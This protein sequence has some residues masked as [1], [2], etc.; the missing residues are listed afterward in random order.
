LFKL[1]GIDHVAI[2]V[3]DLKRALEFY[4][5]ILGLKI[6]EREF[7]KPGV[8]YFLDCG[9][10][11]IGLIQGEMKGKEHFFDDG[12]VG[13]NHV[14][15]RVSKNDFDRAVEV[16][17]Q[18]NVPIRFLKKREKSWS[19]YFSDPDGNKLEITAWPKEDQ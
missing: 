15:F 11:L 14:G 18:K 7:Q 9:S 19:A 4:T 17:K 16:L 13:A 1:D 12:G 5:G 3:S 10:S 8:E 2:N 6:S